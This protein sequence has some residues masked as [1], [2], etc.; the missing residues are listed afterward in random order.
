VQATWTPSLASD[1][2]VSE[3]AT[4]RAVGPSHDKFNFTMLRFHDE[5]WKK[6][7]AG[8]RTAFDPRPALQNRVE[9]PQCP[10]M[11]GKTTHRPSHGRHYTCTSCDSRYRSL[12]SGTPHVRKDQRCVR[13]ENPNSNSWTFQRLNIARIYC[14]LR[15]SMIIACPVERIEPSPL[16]L[17]NGLTSFLRKRH[18]AIFLIACMSRGT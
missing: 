12:T 11:S 1:G 8:Y 10:V 6:L 7:L 9:L 4:N 16:N 18:V 13:I 2:H 15:M 17:S 14:L 5:R 3:D